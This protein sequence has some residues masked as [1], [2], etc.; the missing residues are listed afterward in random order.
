MHRVPGNYSRV[1]HPH[2]QV[3][4]DFFPG[5]ELT[6]DAWRFANTLVNLR[7]SSSASHLPKTPNATPP[8]T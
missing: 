1:T 3:G 2:Q 5:V 7:A 6:I 8:T 4:E